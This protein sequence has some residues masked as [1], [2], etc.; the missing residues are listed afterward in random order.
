MNTTAAACNITVKKPRKVKP[1]RVVNE[2]TSNLLSDSLCESFNEIGAT[3]DFNVIKNLKSL[4]A[5]VPYPIVKARY[6]QTKF[7]KKFLLNLKDG[8]S[9]F[10]P[11]RFSTL[12][13]ASVEKLGCE[14]YCVIYEGLKNFHSDMCFH[15]V[16]LQ[17]NNK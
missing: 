10:L 11:C 7:G 4:E 17:Q 16:Q 13:D 6:V 12:D 9:V 15:K 14:N 2:S 5:N 1:T 8:F 3:C